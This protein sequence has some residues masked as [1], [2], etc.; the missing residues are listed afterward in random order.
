MWPSVPPSSDFV[1]QEK[2]EIIFLWETGSFRKPLAWCLER[3]GHS[4]DTPPEWSGLAFYG[5]WILL[6]AVDYGLRF[7]AWPIACEHGAFDTRVILGA[8]GAPNLP[9]RLWG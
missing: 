5:S 1:L 4:T 2:Q 8:G 7:F 3:S 9:P 6:V